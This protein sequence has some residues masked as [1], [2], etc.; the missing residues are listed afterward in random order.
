VRKR[1][2]PSAI[3]TPKKP[4][5]SSLGGIEPERRTLEEFA[6]IDHLIA[7]NVCLIADRARLESVRTVAG[8]MPSI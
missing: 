2:R 7:P 6:V 4:V 5:E 1:W 8:F 3:A